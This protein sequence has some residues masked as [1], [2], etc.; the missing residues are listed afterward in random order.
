M[1]GSLPDNITGDWL[2]FIDLWHFPSFIAPQT[3]PPTHTLPPPP[4]THTSTQAYGILE[5]TWQ[6]IWLINEPGKSILCHYS[7]D[8]ISLVSHWSD[9]KFKSMYI[10]LSSDLQIAAHPPPGLLLPTPILSN[11]LQVISTSFSDSSNKVRCWC[12]TQKV[13]VGSTRAAVLVDFCLLAKVIIGSSGNRY[14]HPS[15]VVNGDRTPPPPPLD[16]APSFLSSFLYLSPSP[17]PDSFSVGCENMDTATNRTKKVFVVRVQTLRAS[18]QGAL[19]YLKQVRV[20]TRLTQDT[21][22]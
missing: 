20:F 17:L 7:G 19:S 9:V 2:C 21:G 8:V 14:Q 18:I 1:K 13:K 11:G 12:T 22:Y 5:V 10:Q 15:V 3:L 4:H 6:S 16:T